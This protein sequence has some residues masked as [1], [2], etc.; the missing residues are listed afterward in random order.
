RSAAG[1]GARVVQQNQEALVAAAWAQAGDLRA[2]VGLLNRARLAAEVQRSLVTRG[3]SLADAD[4]LRL[5]T[6]LHA[7]LPGGQQSVA[8]LVSGSAV[9]T[10]LLSTAMARLTR[11]GT[12]LARD[13]ASRA[14][15]DALRIGAVH[16]TATV[17]ATGDVTK[18]PSPALTF[19]HHGLPSGAQVV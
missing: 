10:G 4:L 17:A 9:P 13:F 1:L 11:P 7:L 18:T 5:T 2:T 16:V 6:R 19:A 14:N 3:A 12:P 15:D 8:G